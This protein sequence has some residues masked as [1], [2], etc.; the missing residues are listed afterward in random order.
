MTEAVRVTDLS[1]HSLRRLV[2]DKAVTVRQLPGGRVQILRSD[3]ERLAEAWII[4][5]ATE[6]AAEEVV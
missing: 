1:V 6:S 3:L 2:A 4:P 5:A